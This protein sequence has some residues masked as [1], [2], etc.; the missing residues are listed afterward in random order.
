VSNLANISK[1]HC[2][3]ISLAAFWQHFYAKILTF[4]KYQLSV[5][6]KESILDYLSDEYPNVREQMQFEKTLWGS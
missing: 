1:N 4:L 5:L 2:F 6:T 3:P